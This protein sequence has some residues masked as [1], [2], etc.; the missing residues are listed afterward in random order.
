MDRLL[1]YYGFPSS[2]NHADSILRATEYFSSYDTVVFAGPRKNFKSIEFAEHIDHKNSEAIIKNLKNNTFGYV[3]CG[4]RDGVD[5]CWTNS[6]IKE[7]CIRWKN[8]GVK[9]IFLDELGYDFN[10]FKSRKIDILNIVRNLSLNV[11]ANCWNPE[12]LFDDSPELFIKND[13]YLLE[14]LFFFAN[15]EITEFQ[16]FNDSFQRLSIAQRYRNT[17]GFKL[18]C[19][20]SFG[21]DYALIGSDFMD[22]TV[23][24]ADFFSL[25]ALSITK[26]NYHS[27]DVDLISFIPKESGYSKK[28]RLKLFLKTVKR[29]DQNDK[30]IKFLKNITSQLPVEYYL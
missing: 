4:N 12:D 18:A 11:F 22:F 28:F 9:G 23:S 20:N 6:E 10:N 3:A 16:S 17:L 19:V 2:V 29:S 25:D 26:G 7:L 5:S 21:K 27:N 15:G 14:S 1:I 30:Y 13:H 8:M 24:A